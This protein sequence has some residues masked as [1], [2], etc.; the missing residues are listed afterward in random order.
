VSRFHSELSLAVACMWKSR[1]RRVSRWS[2]LHERRSRQSRRRHGPGDPL[3]LLLRLSREYADSAIG[4]QNHRLNLPIWAWPR[5]N[6]RRIRDRGRGK[7][8][9]QT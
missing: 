6:L 5:K 1:T 4:P 3:R 9:R 8:F 7:R 2:A